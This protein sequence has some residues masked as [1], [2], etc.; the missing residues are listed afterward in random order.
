MEKA[1]NHEVVSVYRLD[2]EDQEALMLEQKECVLNWCTRDEWPMGVIHSYIYRKGSVWITAGAHRHRV[3][4]L[5][6][7]PKTSVVITSKG[8]SLEA[9][10]SITIKG[11]SVIHESPELKAWFYPELAGAL[12]S[13]PEEVAAFEAMLDSPLRI[14]IEVIPEKWITYDGAKMRE[15][16]Q[17]TLDPARLSKPLESDSVRLQKEKQ[18]RN[19]SHD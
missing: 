11:R 14:V 17:G 6:R 18:R 19:L 15:H 5:R 10:K 12:R 8:T 2:P 1:E 9:G 16:A 13:T 3:S 4:A 7:N